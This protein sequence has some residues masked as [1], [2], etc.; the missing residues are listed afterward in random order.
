MDGC[1][2]DVLPEGGIMRTLVIPAHLDHPGSLGAE[3]DGATAVEP[4]DGVDAV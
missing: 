4:V 1:F 2:G 3:E